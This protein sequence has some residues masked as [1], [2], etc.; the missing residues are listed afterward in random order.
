MLYKNYLT[1]ILPGL[2]FCAPA[3][4]QAQTPAAP[5]PVKTANIAKV[6]QL[7]QQSGYNARKT[8][9]S[10][11]LLEYPATG[12][13]ILAAAGRDFVVLGIVVA[14]KKNLKQSTELYYKLLKL[15]HSQDYVK[16]VLDDDDDVTVRSEVRSWLLDL[17]QIKAMVEDLNKSAV[18][19]RQEITPF[20]ITP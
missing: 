15:N 2:L 16:I 18:K 13:K 8:G 1:I 4:L 11:W 20:L 5:D 19:I 6:N 14:E 17:R 10:T 12:R 7:L 3:W 9:D